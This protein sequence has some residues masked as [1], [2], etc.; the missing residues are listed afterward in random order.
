[1]PWWGWLLVGLGAWLVLSVIVALALAATL[2]PLG[3]SLTDLHEALFAA[4]A[5]WTNAPLTRER[6]SAASKERTGSEKRRSRRR[7]LR[8]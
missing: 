2:R 8:R 3:L 5:K 7:S 4:F 6:E 1:M